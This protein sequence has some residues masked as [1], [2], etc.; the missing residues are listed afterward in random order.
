MRKILIPLFLLMATTAGAQLNNSWIDYS[1][2]YYKFSVGKTGLYQISQ[3][4]LALLGLDNTPAEQFQLWRNGEQVRLYTSV[5]T[6]ALG[7]GG[8]IE[9]L[10][11]MNDG[12]P[13]KQLYKEPEFQMCDSFSI[14]SDTAA[15]FL[16][17]NPGA[18]NLRYSNAVNNVAGNALPPD[19]YFMRRVSQPF[20]SQYNR[21]YAVVLNEYVYSSS[22]DLGEGWASGDAGP[23]CDL[24]KEFTG[25]NV[26]TAGPAN[27]LSVYVAAFGNALN[28]NLAG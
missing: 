7:A 10:G 28:L 18:G 22:Y 20:K 2:T 24:F 14:H 9:F 15:Y 12:L 19:A 21:G 26:Y 11:K 16:T 4:A 6:G 8:Y 23:C 5:P 17:I 25:L 13:D 3:P 1:K 27:S